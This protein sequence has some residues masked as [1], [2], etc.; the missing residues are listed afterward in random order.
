MEVLVTWTACKISKLPQKQRFEALPEH[1]KKLMKQAIIM[2]QPQKVI[3]FGSRARGDAVANSDFDV[4]FEFSNKKG[5]DQL[6]NW[7]EENLDSLYKYDLIDVD[8]IKSE[9]RE[10]ILKEGVVLYECR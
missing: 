2:I 4:A 8:E 7:P 5:W 6:A 1:L 3:L 9:F 10:K